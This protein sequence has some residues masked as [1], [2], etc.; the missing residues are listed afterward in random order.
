MIGTY[1]GAKVAPLNAVLK[2]NLLECGELSGGKVGVDDLHITIIYSLASIDPFIMK[3]LFNLVELPLTARITGAACFDASPNSDGSKN[4]NQRTLVLKLKS[5]ILEKLHTSLK[6]AGGTHT[7]DTFEPH[8]TIWYDV[9]RELAEPAAEKL[10]K[11]FQH[12]WSYVDITSIY[13]DLLQPDWISS[14]VNFRS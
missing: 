11:I 6:M 3:A 14:S 1:V 13:A 12:G 8:V 2:R 5:G 9:P 4:E 10:D 7:Y